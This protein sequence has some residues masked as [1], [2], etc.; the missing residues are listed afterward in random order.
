[1]SFCNQ[2][3]YTLNLEK[4]KEIAIDDSNELLGL[5][6]KN[7]KCNDKEYMPGKYNMSG[8]KIKGETEARQC[9]IH[10]LSLPPL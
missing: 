10:F 9:M 8:C 4:L 1:L 7:T 5:N 3:K 6:Y 2:N